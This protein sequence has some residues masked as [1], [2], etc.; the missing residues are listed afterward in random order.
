MRK[1]YLSN[2]CAD[3]LAIPRFFT[4]AENDSLYLLVVISRDYF[5]NEYFRINAI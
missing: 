5:K 1:S 4:K 3:N 2:L